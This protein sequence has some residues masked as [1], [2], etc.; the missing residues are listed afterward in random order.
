MAFAARI[1]TKLRDA[2]GPVITANFE[3]PSPAMCT[4]LDELTGVLKTNMTSI[5]DTTENCRSIDVF[6]YDDMNVLDL[7]GPVEAFSHALVL[8][9]NAY[10]TR[11]VS[12]DGAPVRT[13]CGLRLMPDGKLV[14]SSSAN[15]LFLP[16]GKG[17]DAHFG[18]T[19]LQRVVSGWRTKRPD[20]RLISVCSGSL[21]LA[22][23]GVLNGQPATSHW[24]RKDMASAL[25][26]DV[27]WDMNKIYILS[28][29]Y[30]RRPAS[31]REL[32]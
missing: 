18:N 26:P 6:L 28:D 11:Y 29:L 15:D 10:R 3:C 13:S 17:V 1:S 2:K 27:Q 4:T 21:L 5:M 30:L 32:T 8:G 16:G 25:F 23:S 12:L 9:R 7:A 19:F 24:A 22:A 14:S 31:R 20:G